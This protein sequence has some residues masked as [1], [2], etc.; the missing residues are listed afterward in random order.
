MRDKKEVLLWIV[1]DK[2][3]DNGLSVSLSPLISVGLYLEE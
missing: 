3:V 2:V 1:L